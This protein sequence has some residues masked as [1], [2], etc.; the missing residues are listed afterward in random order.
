M[1]SSSTPEQSRGALGGRN[2]G[3]EPL[4]AWGDCAG[5]LGCHPDRGA[6]ID[7]EFGEFRCD[8]GNQLD[9]RSAGTDDGRLLAFEVVGIVPFRRM[10]DLA[11]EGLDARNIG[12]P[13]LRKEPRGCEEIPRADRF[14]VFLQL[15]TRRIQ[16]GPM[17]VWLEPVSYTHLRAHETGRN[18]VC[19]LL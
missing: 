12:H 11:R 1:S 5:L 4:H 9:S 18:L 10:D 13:G 8:F 16:T 17:G 14:G 7:G 6:L 2:P 19:R 3:E 15:R